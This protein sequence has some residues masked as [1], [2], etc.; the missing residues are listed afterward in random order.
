M[1]NECMGCDEAECCCLCQEKCMSPCY[2]STKNTQ[3]FGDCDM[4]IDYKGERI[5]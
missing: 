5:K 2:N 3:C 4:T 1:K